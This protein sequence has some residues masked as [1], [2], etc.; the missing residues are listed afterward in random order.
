MQPSSAVQFDQILCLEVIEH[1]IDGFR[2]LKATRT[3]IL[4]VEQN[5]HM[6]RSLGD[7]VVVMDDGRIVHAGRMAELAGDEALQ[8]R[9]WDRVADGYVT[10]P[11]L[12]GVEVSARPALP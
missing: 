4:L 1:L 9:L 2:E 7:A 12:A 11:P 5:F 8:A 3:T 10:T 6:A